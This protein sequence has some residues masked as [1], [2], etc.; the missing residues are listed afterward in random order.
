MLVKSKKA[1]S[2]VS[3]CV[4]MMIKGAKKRRAGALSAVKAINSELGFATNM[5]VVK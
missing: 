1:T 3:D 4:N 2:N 5:K